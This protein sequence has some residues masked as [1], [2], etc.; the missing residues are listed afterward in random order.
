MYCQE[1]ENLLPGSRTPD[2]QILASN[3]TDSAAM[4]AAVS[5]LFRHP[6]LPLGIKIAGL[7]RPLVE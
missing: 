3:F 2:E 6:V 1:K 7:V 5:F 4:L